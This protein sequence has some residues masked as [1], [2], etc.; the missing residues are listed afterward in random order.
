MT[1]NQIGNA[2][3]TASGGSDVAD[4]FVCA[5]GFLHKPLFPDIPGRES[6]VGPSF[7][8][9]RWD[10]GVPY[11][12]KRWG[13]I[14]SGA[15]GVQI[16][17]ALAWAGCDVTQLIR[18]AQWV[19]IRENPHATWRERLKVLIGPGHKGPQ[20]SAVLEVDTAAESTTDQFAR[21]RRSSQGQSLQRPT[22]G[23]IEECV[24]SVKWYDA[25]RGFGFI[26]RDTDEKDV[27]VHVKALERAGLSRLA[28]GQR[29]RMKFYQGEKGPEARSIQLLD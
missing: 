29:V 21:P 10:H 15:S 23:P 6:F 1:C 7:H 9:A 2:I 4:V 27:F 5:T 26:G 3:E 24:G 28:E 11:D 12:G 17:E 16:T 19:H 18:R 25:E 14:G 22:E 13:V 20:V 8:S